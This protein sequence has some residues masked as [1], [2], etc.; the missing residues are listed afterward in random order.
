MVEMLLLGEE[1]R[2]Q[3]G[4]PHLE[5]RA[6]T[7]VE[8]HEEEE[9]EQLLLRRLEVRLQWPLQHQNQL[10]NR[11]ASDRKMLWVQPSIFLIN[12]PSG[13]LYLSFF[14]LLSSLQVI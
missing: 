6:Q 9:E 8:E 14:Y 10:R 3:R 2:Q 5:D 1:G 13:Q 4:D 7:F 11:Y 12:C